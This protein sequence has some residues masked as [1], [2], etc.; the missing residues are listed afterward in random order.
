MTRAWKSQPTIPAFQSIL[1]DPTLRLFRVTPPQNVR[2]TVSGTTSVTLTW[3][4]ATEPGTYYYV[5][6]TSNANGLDGFNPE[7]LVKLSGT[8][9][10][11]AIGASTTYTYQVR[12]TKLQTSGSG[13]FWNLSQGTFITVP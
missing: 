2:K 8:S 6:R 5:Y 1:G 13:S 3:D 12:A 4:T 11:Q 7:T 10:T 9:F